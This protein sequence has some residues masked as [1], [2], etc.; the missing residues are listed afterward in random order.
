MKYLSLLVLFTCLSLQFGFSQVKKQFLDDKNAKT[1][2]VIKEDAA[3]DMQ[4][5]NSQ[6]DINSIGM[7]QEIRITTQQD[8]PKQSLAE[9]PLAEVPEVSQDI[10]TPKGNRI[11]KK[12]AAKKVVKEKRMPA[13]AVA[14]MQRPKSKPTEIYYKGIGKS[15]TKK[16]KMKK[17]KLVKRKKIRK[18]KRRKVRCYS[19]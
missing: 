18:R 9:V 13:R 8:P 4:I 2:I 12:A 16:V 3:N 11:V 19:F 14:T 5:L 1:T 15:S 7:G 17:R 6:F 10:V